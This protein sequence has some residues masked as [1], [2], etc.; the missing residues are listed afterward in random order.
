MPLAPR[1]PT[2]AVTGASSGI[3]AAIARELMAEGAAVA[4]LARRR[5]RLDTLAREFPAERGMPVPCDV[6]SAAAVAEA[7]GQV[8]GRFPDGLDLV[9]AAA[10]L[11]VIGKADEVPP[12]AYR[13]MIE[14]NVLGLIETTR[15]FL[16][17][18]R[19]KK[20]V[21]VVVSSILARIG[22]PGLAGYCASKFAVRGF[23][24]SLRFE[25]AADGVAV[26]EVCPGSTDTEF[27][28]AEAPKERLPPSSRIIPLQRPERVAT[29]ALRAAAKRRTRVTIPGWVAPLEWSV[30]V[31]PP[32]ARSIQGWL[33]RS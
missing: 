18:L 30:D 15:A 12:E 33:D 31:A 22:A 16:P 13:R 8:A 1:F 29:M 27:F 23:V 28:S 2:A 5:D 10:G 4:L 26:V 14:T 17:A 19:R 6:T 11:A 21:L 7:A 32:L 3:G 25:L 24:A 9:V 20:G